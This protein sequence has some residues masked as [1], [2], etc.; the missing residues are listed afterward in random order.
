MKRTEKKNIIRN[1]R[2]KKTHKK[3]R[4]N[5]EHPRISVYR[6]NTYISAQCIA[7]GAGNTLAFATSRGLEKGNKTEA[8]R[9]VGLMLAKEA[10]KKNVKKVVFDRGR[11]AYHG[12]V[13][14]LAE[15]AREGGLEF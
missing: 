8:A 9:E 12:R 5:L 10:L 7:D 4:A 2:A 1:R 14:A 6:S 15:G 11:Y 13:K 3:M